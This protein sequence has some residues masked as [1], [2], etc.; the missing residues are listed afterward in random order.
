MKKRLFISIIL[1]IAIVFATLSPKLPVYADGD[2]YGIWLGSTLV[3]KSNYNDILG[4]GTAKYEPS[5]NTLTL[6]YPNIEG[7]HKE[8]QLC[9]MQTTSTPLTI[10]GFADFLDKSADYGILGIESDIILRGVFDIY[11]KKSGILGWT[12]QFIGCNV[13]IVGEQEYGIY[14]D[15]EVLFTMGSGVTEVEG[16]IA[17]V[18][19]KDYLG[20]GATHDVLIPEGGYKDPCE[21]GGYYI[22]DKERNIV[23]HA[24]IG[25]ACLPVLEAYYIEKVDGTDSVTVDITMPKEGENIDD[26]YVLA[27]GFNEIELWEGKTLTARSSWYNAQTGKI[28][29]KGDV[30]EAGIEYKLQVYLS[31]NITE[32]G[33]TSINEFRTGTKISE[34]CYN[35]SFAKIEEEDEDNVVLTAYFKIPIPEPEPVNNDKNNNKNNNDQKDNKIDKQD[36]VKQNAK[37]YSNEWVDGKWYNADG[38][39]DYAG[40]L[41]WKCNS[42]GWWVEDSE[43]W[44]PV[45][46]WQKIDGKWYYFTETGYMDYSEY[47]DGCWLGSDG[48]WVEE[49]YGGH[50]CSD[51]TGWWYEDSAGWYPHDQ[52]LWIDGVQY[53]FNSAG[54][55]A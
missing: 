50:W 13:H 34:N 19:A 38:V 18:Y 4:D 8:A 24:K 15:E 12:C 26:Y 33:I 23:K 16:G 20:Y 1:V 49:Y 5:T 14:S 46:Q 2:S 27:K 48:A 40:I 53:W 6:N 30:I 41:T 11:G 3:T 9:V 45:S 55:W 35:I 31:G 43:G 47:R 54:Y 36:D 22:Y 17:A 21:T 32:K 37:K 25:P 51:S 39:C 7:T 44:Y 29:K 52:Y 42:T 10:K 28:L